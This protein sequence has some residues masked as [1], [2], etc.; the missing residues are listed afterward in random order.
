MHAA[1]HTP[2]AS[3]HLQ[4]LLD[5]ADGD[6]AVPAAHAAEVVRLHVGAHLEPVHQHG[7]HGGRGA[8]DGAGG[9]QDVDVLGGQARLLQQLLQ[10]VRR[11]RVPRSGRVGNASRGS[12]W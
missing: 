9:D 10:R 7:R 4:Q 1:Q 3:Q 6:D 5:E 11:A 12:A 8:E 2:S